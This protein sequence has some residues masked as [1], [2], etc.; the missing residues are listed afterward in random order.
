MK[1]YYLTLSKVF[2][3]THARAGSPTGFKKKFLAAVSGAKD[4]WFK[5]YDLSEPMVIIHFTEFRY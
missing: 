3:S 1:T 4:E 5:T 2:P